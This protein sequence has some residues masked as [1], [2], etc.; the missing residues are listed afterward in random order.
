MLDRARLSPE[1]QVRK[2]L[3]QSRGESRSGLKHW[4]GDGEGWSHLQNG[5]SEGRGEQS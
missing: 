4:D 2:V 5:I 3:P 1:A